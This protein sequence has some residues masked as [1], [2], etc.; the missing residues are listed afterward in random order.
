MI[1]GVQSELGVSLVHWL[2]AKN[3]ESRMNSIACVPPHIKGINFLNM[4][5]VYY[6]TITSW[7]SLIFCVVVVIPFIAI[8]TCKARCM[9][10]LFRVL[11]LVQ[12]LFRA[13]YRTP[14]VKRKCSDRRIGVN[15]AIGEKAYQ[16]KH[17]DRRD[18]VSAYL[19]LRT[20]FP[21]TLHLI[22]DLLAKSTIWTIKLH[23]ADSKRLENRK[24][25]WQHYP[26]VNTN[27][28][29][30]NQHFLM[31]KSTVNGHVQ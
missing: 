17:S 31:G 1:W 8:I 7:A 2:A 27:I 22:S 3:D 10:S 6:S 21:N 16:R 25:P 19:R 24:V 30:E 13:G 4:Y 18:G 20:P 9:K 23:I 11:G 5:Y 12:G 15:T 26:L 14:S 29:T 28:T